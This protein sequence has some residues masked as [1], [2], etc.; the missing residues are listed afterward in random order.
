MKVLVI[1]YDFDL[2][3]LFKKILEKEGHTVQIYSE[4]SQEISWTTFDLVLLDTWQIYQEPIILEKITQTDAIICLTSTS[5]EN[6]Q[7]ERIKELDY[8]LFLRKPFTR[9]TLTDT[10]ITMKTNQTSL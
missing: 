2:A 6:N 7:P 3:N 10:I 5:Y 9:K 1:E 8:H 4:R